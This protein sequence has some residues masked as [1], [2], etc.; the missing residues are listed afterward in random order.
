MEPMIQGLFEV[1]SPPNGAGQRGKVARYDWD[2][3]ANELRRRPHRGFVALNVRS[4]EVDDLK[5]Y[6]PD[7]TFLGM[8]HRMVKTP[9][10]KET[11]TC[12]VYMR[13]PKSEE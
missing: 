11:K 12:D 7:I 8:T 5:A 4:D 1:A 6:Y 13:F 2:A 9:S 3:I 10:G